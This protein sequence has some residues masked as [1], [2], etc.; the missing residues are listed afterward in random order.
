MTSVKKLA[1][2]GT[3]WTIAGYGASQVLRLGGNLVLTRLLEPRLFGL[4]TLV[5]VFITALHLF[6]DIGI[7]TSIVQNKRGD[8]P[9]FL[10]TAWTLQVARGGVLWLCSLLL[11]WPVAQF[12][13][14]P[15][16]RWLLPTVALTALISGFNSTAY[17]TLNRHIDVRKL[18]LYE[19][20][21][22][23]ISLLV[24]I[25]WAMF[26]NKT[27]WALVVG[28]LASEIMGLVW[29]YQLMPNSWN[30]FTWDKESAKE[31][32]SFGKW[33]FLS[34]AITFFGEQADR[35]IFGKLLSFE[36]LGIYGIAMTFADLPRSVTMAINGKVIFPAI[37]KFA[38]LPREELRAKLNHNRKPILLALAVGLALLASFGD[39]LIKVLYDKRYWD[40]AWMLPILAVGIWPRLLCNTN[41]PSLFA[42]G[43]PQYS[44][45]ANF[46]RF[47][48]TSLGVWF[49]YTLLKVP[50]AIIAVALNDLLY[51]LAV[52]YGLWR[53]GLGGMKL[54][55]LATMLLVALLA[56]IVIGRVVLGFHL[57]IDGL[58]N[59][60]NPA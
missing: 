44:T 20:G 51:Y 56:L 11:A 55:I 2:R 9:A 26:I 45:L 53:E 35:L 10:N 52:N 24:T 18:S 6:S 36:L 41:E 57:P 49:G 15:Q 29:S 48:C 22:Q 19:F 1:I 30:R 39:V 58:L 38:D 47:V 43:K 31:L 59:Y 50:G 42:I 23:F 46:T 4:M 21:R 8:E 54:D 12:Y 7:G 34:T 60:Y 33:I 27:I 3:L 16:L 28:T 5:Y 14:E 25:L 13:N 40:A 17:F 37:S 32:L